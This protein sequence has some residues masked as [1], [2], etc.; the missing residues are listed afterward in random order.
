MQIYWE[1]LG[2]NCETDPA[3]EREGKTRQDWAAQERHRQ[4]ISWRGVCLAWQWWRKGGGGKGG[5][6][7]SSGLGCS[8]MES[9][10]NEFLIF[11]FLEGGAPGL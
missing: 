8:R 11:S 2:L 9:S 10:K 4:R 7:D 6:M 3:V 1:L 5:G